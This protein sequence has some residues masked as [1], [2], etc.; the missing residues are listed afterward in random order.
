MKRDNYID[1]LEIEANSSKLVIDAKPLKQYFYI[2][3]G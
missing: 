2:K 1:E 3:K